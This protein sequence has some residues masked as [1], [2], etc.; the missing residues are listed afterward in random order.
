[1]IRGKGAQ[2]Q[3]LEEL[4]LAVN[5]SFTYM[6]PFL[7]VP[8]SSASGICILCVQWLGEDVGSGGTVEGRMERSSMSLGLFFNSIFH[9]SLLC[10]EPQ[11]A[12]HF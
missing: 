10:W 4:N 3:N 12:S 11:G 5:L 6:A 7:T 9:V 2:N 1:M 8:V